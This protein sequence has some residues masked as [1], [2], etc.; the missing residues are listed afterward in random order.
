MAESQVIKMDE[1]EERETARSAR[2]HGADLRETA[3]EIRQILGP[4]GSG[5]RVESRQAREIGE[6]ETIHLHLLLLHH[7]CRAET[8]RGTGTEREETP[9]R[10]RTDTIQ[11][12]SLTGGRG[13]VREKG[14]RKG[15][16][17]ERK[18]GKK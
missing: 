1:T 10:W 7:L 3:R 6:L 16:K 2:T 4:G 12:T 17:T 18:K 5:V 9:G 14:R 15:R 13:T 8:G 11:Q